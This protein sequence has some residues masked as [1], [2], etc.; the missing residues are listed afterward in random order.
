MVTHRGKIAIGV[1]VD[2]ES[3]GLDMLVLDNNLS[4]AMLEGAS[5]AIDVLA[6][7]LE[8]E[9]KGGR[10]P[11][12]TSVTRM[13]GGGRAEART[14]DDIPGYRELGT[15]RHEIS[16]RNP[17]GRLIFFWK[18]IGR[19]FIG[20]PGQSVMHPGVKPHPFVARRGHMALPRLQAEFDRSVGE[21]LND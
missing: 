6:A 17:R 15:P 11:W 13:P 18:R 16:P 1:D 10:H 8:E 20:G 21:V 9:F 2:D 12:G 5:G 14:F 3:F 4:E 7:E 19:K